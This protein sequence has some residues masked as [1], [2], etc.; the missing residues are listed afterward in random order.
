[1]F[2]PPEVRDLEESKMTPEQ[3]KIFETHPI[4]AV[5]ALA[6]NP[7]VS[8]SV[9]TIILQHHEH[10]DGSGYPA[11]LTGIRIFPLAKVVSLA[12]GFTHLM[13][14]KNTPPIETLKE[15]LSDKKTFVKYEPELLKNLIKGMTT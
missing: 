7:S 2:L 10:V 3:R 15:L 4:L 12:D 14:A 9:K 1:M 13:K 6:N 8:H 11:G 5:D